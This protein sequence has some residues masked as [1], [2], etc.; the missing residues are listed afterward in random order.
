MTQVRL[1]SISPSDIEPSIHLPYHEALNFFASLN[2]GEYQNDLEVLGYF[3]TH[4]KYETDPVTQIIDCYPKDNHPLY[5]ELQ[6]IVIYV[7]ADSTHIEKY[8]QAKIISTVEEIV[9][10]LDANYLCGEKE[11]LSD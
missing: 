9:K 10:K 6:N 11:V 3:C 5:G 1:S 4:T 8:G 7:N 2:E